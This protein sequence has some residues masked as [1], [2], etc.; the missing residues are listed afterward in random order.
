MLYRYAIT[1]Y[2]IGMRDPEIPGKNN[3]KTALTRE[4]ERQCR[5]DT[6]LVFRDESAQQRWRDLRRRC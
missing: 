3:A 1:C 6:S 5:T 4:H 2:S